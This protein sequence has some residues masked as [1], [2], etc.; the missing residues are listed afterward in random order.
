MTQTPVAP[1]HQARLDAG[2]ACLDAALH[3]Y[4]PLG[5]SITCCCD[6]DHIG[7]GR[8]HAKACQDPGKAPMHPWKAFQTRVPT[9]A[10]V[11]AAWERYPIGNVGC[12]LGQVSGLVRID[13]DG[14]AGRALLEAC[15]GGDLPPT[16]TFRSGSGGRGLLYRWSQD[17]PCKTT[18][19]QTKGAHEELRLM[20]NGS[21]T[22]LPPSRHTSGALYTWEPGLSPRRPGS[23]AC[24]SLAGGALAPGA[25]TTTDAT[26]GQPG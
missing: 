12:V 22:V 2:Q 23:C 1:D 19:H 8:T 17:V 4:L 10:E 11:Q 16:W 26:H 24:P 9:A 13:E 14:Q 21:Q 6:P 15:S 25:A 5:L 3:T 20:G 18:A 7:V